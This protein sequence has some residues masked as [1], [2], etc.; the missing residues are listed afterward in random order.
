MAS[1]LW[2]I[3]I[4]WSEIEKTSA[5]DIMTSVA[6]DPFLKQVMDGLI[7]LTMYNFILCAATYGN[8]YTWQGHCLTICFLVSDLTNSYNYEKRAGLSTHDAR[9]EKY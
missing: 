2:V 7:N 9:P 8:A 4:K 1:I 3:E 6:T 5:W